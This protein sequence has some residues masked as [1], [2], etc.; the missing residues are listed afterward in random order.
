MAID[1]SVWNGTVDQAREAVA[2]AN[3]DHDRAQSDYDAAITAIRKFNAS[4]QKAV[5]S[6]GEVERTLASVRDATDALLSQEGTLPPE[7]AEPEPWTPTA[8]VRGMR[9]K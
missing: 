7:I 2:T 5:T 8:P 3:D 1:V 9:K 4:R 6:L